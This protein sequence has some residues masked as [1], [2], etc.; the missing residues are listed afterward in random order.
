M[1]DFCRLF[2]QI[3]Q[4][5]I[6]G[7][8]LSII[9]RKFIFVHITRQFLFLQFRLS[10]TNLIQP[11]ITNNDRHKI[12]LWEITIILSILLRTHCIRIFLRII[13]SPGFLN[14]LFACLDQINLTF[15]FGLDRTCDCLKRIQVFHLR[16]RSKLCCSY[17]THG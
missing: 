14:N 3:C 17:F 11:L 13:P 7:Q 9:L 5:L 10:C 6:A 8:N 12:R 16:S 2:E 1:T 4:M 15:S